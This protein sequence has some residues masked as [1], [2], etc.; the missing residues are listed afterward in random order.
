MSTKM[1]LMSTSTSPTWRSIAA[2]ENASCDDTVL[3]L[4][5]NLQVDWL[6]TV[7]QFAYSDEDSLLHL[8][9]YPWSQVTITAHNHTRQHS[10][11]IP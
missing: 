10:S 4:S 6:L 3:F 7:E 8:E 5:L 11:M 1:A 9:L 2:S